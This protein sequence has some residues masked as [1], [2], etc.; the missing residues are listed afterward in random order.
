MTVVDETTG[1][2]DEFAMLERDDCAVVMGANT[3][4]PSG[5]SGVTPRPTAEIGHANVSEQI[6]A[7]TEWHRTGRCITILWN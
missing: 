1:S 5:S 3:T 7:P 6:L 4:V 2:S